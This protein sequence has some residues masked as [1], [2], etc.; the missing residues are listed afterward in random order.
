VA[1]D[2][3]VYPIAAY[4]FVQQGLAYTVSHVFGP[5]AR[6]VPRH[7]TGQ[8]LCEGLRQLASK[9]WGYL[10]GAVLGGWNITSTID[11]GR[12]VFS[13]ARHGA[14][15]TTPQ[16]TLEDFRGVYDFAKVFETSYQIPTK[17]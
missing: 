14:M 3:G 7:V 12:I 6:G 5:V 2:L 11:F 17:W 13:L 16:D 9:R 4:E 10:A 15:A 1:E 8:Q